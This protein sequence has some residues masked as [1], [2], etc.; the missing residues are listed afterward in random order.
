MHHYSLS[1]IVSGKEDMTNIFLNEP[2]YLFLVCAIG[3]SQGSFS[4]TIDTKTD[5]LVD[6]SQL[7]GHAPCESHLFLQ[8]V[9]VLCWL[10][11]EE[12]PCGVLLSLTYKSLLPA[13]VLGYSVLL[14]FVV[15][16]KTAWYPL[17]SQ[18][19]SFLNWIPDQLLES[20][21][22]GGVGERCF[23]CCKGKS[24]KKK[25]KRIWTEFILVP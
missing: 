22:G 18:K 6:S 12:N 13:E 16:R 3:S 5:H 2:K 1:A 20:R 15:P 11:K 25:K 24:S 17:D 4:P 14:C 10:K 23:C 21:I 8:T 19:R 7:C 9:W